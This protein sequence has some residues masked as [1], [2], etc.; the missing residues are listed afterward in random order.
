MTKKVRIVSAKTADAEV[1]FEYADDLSW[2]R[3]T[4]MAKIATFSRILRRLLPFQIMGRSALSGYARLSSQK[5]GIGIP[6]LL[7]PGP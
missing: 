7:I 2:K 3:K 1:D 4:L 5:Q 6:W